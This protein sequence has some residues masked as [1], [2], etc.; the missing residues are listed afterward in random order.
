MNV[1][2][3]VNQ[4]DATVKSW[5]RFL[6]NKERKWGL[7]GHDMGIHDL[8]LAIGGWIPTKVT[9]IGGRSGM[10]K[11]ALITP[12][13]KGAARVLNGRRAEF[14]MFSWEMEAS[15]M[16]DRYISMETGLSSRFLTQG[17]KLLPD[18][19][20]DKI[21]GA[22]TNAKNLP[23]SYQQHSTNIS[24]V[25]KIF[26]EF[27]EE[28]K[29][30]AKLEGVDIIPVGIIDFIG[31]AQYEGQG[32][33][34]Y[35][36]GDF[37]SQIKQLCNETGAC[38]LIIAQINRS[39]DSKEY[40]DRA[41]FSDSQS[42]ENNSDNLI[43]IHRPE[44]VGADTIKDPKSGDMLDAKNK[45]MFRVLKGRDFGIGDFVSSCE[46]KNYR[47]WNLNHEF[48]FEYWNLYNDEQFWKAHFDLEKLERELIL[49]DIDN[50]EKARQISFS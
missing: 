10:G 31:M 46:I 39:V 49:K 41:D 13:L 40:P 22:Y 9:T 42:I 5:N 25:R 6:E 29:K 50:E 11:T 15:L 7:Y 35:G 37:M 18:K 3:L 47:F 17:A 26:L 33:R 27:V 20:I 21:K 2:K 44:Y 45:M 30:K 23:I 4:K 16:V 34:T 43:A 24:A 36:I 1:E 28:T 8:N 38:F 12:M 48:D 19:V 32:L 14:C